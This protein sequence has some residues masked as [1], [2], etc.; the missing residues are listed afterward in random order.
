MVAP[1]SLPRMTRNDSILLQD[2]RGSKSAHLL[3][4]QSIFQPERSACFAS[5]VACPA[6]DSQ[7]SPFVVVSPDTLHRYPLSD[8]SALQRISNPKPGYPSDPS[9]IGRWCSK[10]L[11]AGHGFSRIL[12]IFSLTY[13]LTRAPTPAPG[14]LRPSGTSPV[15]D[16][17]M[18][19]ALSPRQKPL[20]WE[21][22]S[23]KPQRTQ[24]V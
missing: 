9:E 3:C 8:F 15:P 23:P 21:T 7:P 1:D 18:P 19:V 2:R 12:R 20:A 13:L 11:A 5:P 17:S 6:T 14:K 10:R 4:G 24:S 16:L 22:P